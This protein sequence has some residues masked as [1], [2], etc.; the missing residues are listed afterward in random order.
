M[1][2]RVLGWYGVP[3]GTVRIAISAT[4]ANCIWSVWRTL[5]RLKA[6]SGWELGNSVWSSSSN[7][8]TIYF[9]SGGSRVTIR[10]LLTGFSCRTANER[11]IALYLR[12]V[13]VRAGLLL[14]ALSEQPE[15]DTN[16]GE[17]KGNANRAADDEAEVRA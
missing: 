5:S 17:C 1:C 6:I 7:R 4:D 8:V 12:C 9:G 13:F 2:W 3:G 10:V 14:A 15:D 16:Q 11:A